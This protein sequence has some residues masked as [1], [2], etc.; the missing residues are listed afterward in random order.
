M[1]RIL[2]VADNHYGQHCAQHLAPAFSGH[3]LSL[4]EDDWRPLESDDLLEGYDLLALHAIAGTCGNPLP[5]AEA[6]VQVRRW[7]EAGRPLLLLHGS[8]AAFWHWPWWQD[9]V[10]W[11]WVRPN[12]PAGAPASTHPIRPYR[13]QPAKS[14]HPLASRLQPLDIPSDE[15]YIH[16]EQVCP[17]W[18]I[19]ETTTDEG[20]FPMVH[21]HHSPWGGAILGF[22]PGHAAA[23]TGH[24]ELHQR[25]RCCVDWLLSAGAQK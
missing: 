18:T 3:H 13:L 19:M 16:L 20:T 17:S 15:I 1:S 12:D 25:L 14:R 11:R 5:G 8:S 24:P 7:L 2:L 21:A 10:G 23:V 6:E 4:V 9:L 22:L